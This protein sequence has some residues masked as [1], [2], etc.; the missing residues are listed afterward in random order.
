VQQVDVEDPGYKYENWGSTAGFLKTAA[1]AES[2]LLKVGDTKAYKP[3]TADLELVH[4]LLWSKDAVPEKLTD[5]EGFVLNLEHE[6]IK[7]LSNLFQG[8]K[9]KQD[10]W[11]WVMSKSLYLACINNTVQHQC[12]TW[13]GFLSL[14]SRLL[15]NDYYKFCTK[16]KGLLKRDGEA[17]L[18]C[19][20]K[21]VKTL[22]E[23]PH[24]W[25]PWPPLRNGLVPCLAGCTTHVD[26]NGVSA[27]LHLLTH[28][29]DE[30]GI[31]LRNALGLTDEYI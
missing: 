9:A 1:H 10:Q 28:H 24:R 30:A 6:R 5:G 20:A 11:K 31:K 8:H 27:L 23:K 7:Q 3:K 19:C 18:G 13:S 17:E 26:A 14:G 21:L 22:E 12:N 29:L 15:K 4:K 25:F 16:C 2:L